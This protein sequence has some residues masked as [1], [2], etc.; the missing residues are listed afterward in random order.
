MAPA[1]SNWERV[2]RK[3]FGD[4]GVI[5]VTQLSRTKGAWK[6]GKTDLSLLLAEYCLKYKL[7]TEVASNINT[8]GHF[9]QI[10]DL[11]YLRKWLFGSNRTKLYI[12]DEMNK[13]IPSR[14]AM[15]NKNVGVI[16]IFP[17]IS[18][19][20]ARLIC[21]GQDLLTVDKQIVRDIWVRGLFIKKRLNKVEVVSELFEDVY[22]FTVPKTSI[23]FDPY[24]T[25]PFTEKPEHPTLQFKDGSMYMLHDYAEETKTKTE[26]C[27]ENNIHYKQF[28]RILRRY[29]QKTLPMFEKLDV[30]TTDDGVMACAMYRNG[31]SFTDIQRQLD[32]NHPNEAKRLLLKGL[33]YLL[34]GHSKEHKIAQPILLHST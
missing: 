32:L 34:R 3:I 25:A 31:A 21:V 33:D 2:L 26:I 20:R 1:S 16:Q 4:I 9:Q 22:P 17:E 13:H 28:D 23:P 27:E 11:V 18:K 29:L 15:S 5:L 12:F 14:R 10:S 19:A 30:T 7:V 6:L 24:E 8:F